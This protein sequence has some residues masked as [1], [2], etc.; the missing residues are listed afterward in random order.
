MFRWRMVSDSQRGLNLCKTN[1]KCTS[2]YT[3]QNHPAFS[4][5][6]DGENARIAETEDGAIL[7]V[8]VMNSM[9]VVRTRPLLSWLKL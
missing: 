9:P 7:D 5:R 6:L 2:D 3:V 1:S 4:V 8:T